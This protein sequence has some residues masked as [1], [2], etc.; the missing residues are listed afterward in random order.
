MSDAPTLDQ[1]I[2]DILTDLRAKLGVRS[3]DL[4]KALAKVRHRLPRRIYR[5]GMTLVAAEPLAAHPRLRLTLDMPTLQAAATEITTHLATIDVGERR[6][7]WL[8]GMLG[9]LS[10]NLILMFA[11]LIGFLVWRGI[12]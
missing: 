10:F 8:L 11:L 12:L 6:K 4:T 1:M 9:G 5:Q 7:S 3:K 2:A